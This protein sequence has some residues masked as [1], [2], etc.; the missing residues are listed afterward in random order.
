MQLLTP[1]LDALPGYAAALERGWSPDNIRG[2][3]VA[4]EELAKIEADAPAFVALQ[5]DRE[6]KGP[7]IKLPDGSTAQRIPGYH[8]WMWDGD[9]CGVIGFRW[10]P[11]TSALPPH[12]LG[13]IG[14]GVVPWKRRK[15]YATVALGLLLPR[16]RKEGLAW[17]DITTDPE[18][19]ASQ[20]VILANGGV[21]VGPYKK[22]AP[23]GEAD[24][25][26][27]RIQ[28]VDASSR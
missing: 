7:P 11:G 27:Y 17:V 8:L 12:V 1:S 28:L 18:N 5:V 10:Q 4:R 24:G 16:A 23:Y 2:E 20:R 25:L 15:G 21:L 13:H 26:R 19:V 22:P 6:A 14:Y 9:F 3:T